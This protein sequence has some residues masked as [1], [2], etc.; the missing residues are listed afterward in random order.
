MLT[1]RVGKDGEIISATELDTMRWIDGEMVTAEEW[2][3][4][5][6]LYKEG[7]ENNEVR[8]DKADEETGHSA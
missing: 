6:C 1:V 3:K 5:T 8:G 4:L 2:K 7:K